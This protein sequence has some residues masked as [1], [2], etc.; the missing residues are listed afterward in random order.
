MVAVKDGRLLAEFGGCNTT[1]SLKAF[2]S[3]CVIH[4]YSVHRT[5]CGRKEMSPILKGPI[6]TSEEPQ[7]GLVHQCGGLQ[8]PRPVF[9]GHALASHQ[10]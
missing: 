5:C 3:T 4:A 9:V 6:S 2:T 7:I 10:M 8:R 1:T